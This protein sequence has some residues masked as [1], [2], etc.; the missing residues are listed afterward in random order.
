MAFSAAAI[1]PVTLTGQPTAAS[2]PS[3]EITTPPPVMSRFMVVIDS[4][5]LID[6]PPVSKVMPLPTSTTRGVLDARR[7][8]C[9]R[10]GSG[11]T[12]WTEARPTPMIP[13]KPSFS[14]RASSQIVA[15]RPVSSASDSAWSAS[16]SGLLRLDGHGGQDAGPP[17]GAADR[18]RPAQR[19]VGGLVGR[20]TGQHDLGHRRA[21]GAGRAPVEAE[22]AEHRADHERFEPDRAGRGRDRGGDAAA[23]ADG[24]ASAAPARRRSVGGCVADADEQ[25]QLEGVVVGAAARDRQLRD[26][27]RLARGMRD[28]EAPS[29]SRPARSSISRAPGP[30]TT[31]PPSPS[32]GSTG[33]ATTSTPRTAC[34]SAAAQGEFGR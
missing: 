2:A 5:G 1:S 24:R 7:A 33:S 20:R 25:H 31:P 19:C 14:R 9:S 3:T 13:P 29:R 17:A 12:G 4:A 26:L 32:P 6:R 15:L 21:L 34:G 28:V 27:T 8:G 23:V 30:S 22:R 10:D 11:T 16:Q 18:D